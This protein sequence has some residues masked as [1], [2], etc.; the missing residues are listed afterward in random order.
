[1]NSKPMMKRAIAIGVLLLVLFVVSWTA[2]A[3]TGG[4]FDLSWSSVDGGGGNSTGGDFAL[5]GTVGQPDASDALTGGEFTLTGG[6]HAWVSSPVMCGDV[7]PAGG[8]DRDVDVLDAL[9]ALKISVGL[10]VPTPREMIAGDIHPDNNPDPDGD[11]DNDVL[12]ALRILKASVGLVAI[13]SCGGPVHATVLTTDILDFK[14]GSFSV[15]VGTTVVWTNRDFVVHTVTSGT[16]DEPTAGSLFDSGQHL[17][18][19]LKQGD[20]FSH[21]FDQMG[22]FPYFCAIHPFMVGVVTVQ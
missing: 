18:D 7:H 16:P 13:T 10:V 15:P 19:W 21:T 14:L 3:Q 9:R 5:V 2:L 6:F 20:S 4:G 11:G 12:D 1:M 8:G 17:S 22:T